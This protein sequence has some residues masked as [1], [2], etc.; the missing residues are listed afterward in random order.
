M[1]KLYKHGFVLGKFMPPTKGHVFLCEFARQQCEVLTI[2]VGSLPTEPIAGL[3]RFQWMR[4][5]FPDCEVVW[6]N[7]VLPQE[8]KDENDTEFW[9]IWR[10]AIKR[11]TY[12]I[13]I[14][15]VAASEPYGLR[16]AA[17]LNAQFMPCD[18]G[19][20][21]VPIS[22]TKVRNNMIGNWDYLPDVVKKHFTKR[23]CVFGPESTGKS[24]LA[25][26]LAA[27]YQTVYVPEYGRTYTE[28]FGSD[29]VQ[30]DDLKRIVSGHMASVEAAY[31]TANSIIIEDT[32]PVMTA[33]WSDMLNVERDPFLE[34]FDGY[35]DLYLLCDVDV[36]WVNDGYRYFEDQNERQRFFDLCEKEL[37]RRG[38]NYA[39]IR[40]AY[41]VREDVAIAAIDKL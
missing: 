9:D 32:D 41:D 8:P 27:H 24:T 15:M 23:V 14:D 7:E 5:L 16:L 10:D 36:P 4:K 18:M 29:A 33:C 22:A 37:I 25:K 26:K 34:E 40:G 2:M 38:V 31:A 1:Q 11:Y 3:L 17:E 35:A 6:C 13:D 12:G 19:R 30:G 28:M 20:E 39:I 21:A